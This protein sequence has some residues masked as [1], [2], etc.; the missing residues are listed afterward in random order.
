MSSQ[1]LKIVADAHIWGVESAFASLPGFDVD[2]HAVE[3]R[4][5]THEALKDADILLT[6]SSTRV[7]EDLLKGT[8]VRFAATATIGDDHYDKAWLEA[9]SIAWANAA[10]S[11]TGSVIEYMLTALLEL[12]QQQRI[13]IPQTRLGIIGVGRIG[14][15]LATVCETMGMSLLLNDP[16]RAR[17]EGEAFFA[18]IDQLL[19]EADLLTLHTPLVRE[20]D[21]STCHLIDAQLLSRFRGRGIIN[22]ARGG[23][24][25]NEA[26][27]DWL[28][29]DS[30][31]FALLDCWEREPHISKRLLIHPQVVIATPHIA[32]HSLDGKAA[33]TQ[34]VYDALCQ[35]L[36]VE[37]R[38]RMEEVLPAADPL[39]LP[40]CGDA[41]SDM[42][43]IA[44]SLYPI[45]RDVV[46]MRSWASLSEE[47]SAG[48]FAAYRRHYPVR[49]SWAKVNVKLE[50]GAVPPLFKKVVHLMRSHLLACR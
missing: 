43:A 5:I 25:D 23:C 33:N 8:S 7:N 2:L 48:A 22:A 10:G 49:R 46:E 15:M 30:E 47:D 29:N 31:R 12:H 32:G 35:Y 1:S 9:N 36:G 11:S 24:V 34:Y 18:S 45:K 50:S 27:A 26:L 13:D 14:G 3:S 37:Q 19:Q 21:E 39:M 38:W 42:H 44:L 28:D 17:V 4:D 16:P 41:W 6:R 40:C 20:G